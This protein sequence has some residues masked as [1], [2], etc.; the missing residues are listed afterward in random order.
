MTKR[1]T[2]FFFTFKGLSSQP[3]F[4]YLNF[5]FHRH[6]KEKPAPVESLLAVRL[7]DSVILL[8]TEV[9]LQ[10]IL[11]HVHCFNLVERRRTWKIQE[12][13]VWLGKKI[14]QAGKNVPTLL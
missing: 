12:F 1:K 2:S 14:L 4:Q 6:F 11:W 9:Q 3:F 5:S 10:V 8:L 13:V 7:M